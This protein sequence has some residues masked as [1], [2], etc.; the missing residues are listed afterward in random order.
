MITIGKRSP[1][2]VFDLQYFCS[3]VP[4]TAWYLIKVSGRSGDDIQPLSQVG[5]PVWNTSLSQFF[6]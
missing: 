1:K 5:F 3:E 4:I 6:I 2:G